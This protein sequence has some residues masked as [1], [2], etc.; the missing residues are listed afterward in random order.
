MQ[1][2]PDKNIPE[3]HSF[4]HLFLLIFATSSNIFFLLSLLRLSAFFAGPPDKLAE[5]PYEKWIKMWFRGQGGHF[6][7][8]EGISAF[9]LS[10]NTSMN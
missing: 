1:S 6:S 2:E 7:G 8:Q 10:L 4:P 9:R 3:K 5:A